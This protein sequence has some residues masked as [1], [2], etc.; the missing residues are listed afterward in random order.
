VLL[1]FQGGGSSTPDL[2]KEGS[3]AQSSSSGTT[4]PGFTFFKLHVLIPDICA[5]GIR[6]KDGQGITNLTKSNP[7]IKKIWISGEC[8]PGTDE[9]ICRVEG[10]AKGVAVVLAFVADKIRDELWNTKKDRSKQ[11]QIYR[12]STYLRLLQFKVLSVCVFNES[13]VSN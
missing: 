13:N 11:V 8:N 3:A 4:I 2:R 5:D 1:S 7:G 9:R 12:R 6:G 10:D